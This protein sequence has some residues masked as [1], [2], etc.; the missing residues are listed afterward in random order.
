MLR[1]LVV[2]TGVLFLVI[3][4]APSVGSAAQP[5]VVRS[6]GGNANVTFSG[7]DATGCIVTDVFVDVM[8]NAV[9]TAPGTPSTTSTQALLS[10]FQFDVCS[11][12]FSSKGGF[13]SDVSFH[14]DNSLQQAT[15]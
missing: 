15:M 12:T 9:R 11:S 2:T 13:Q 8:E 5:T 6:Q 1:N 14:V 4:I 10:V 7:T 3:T